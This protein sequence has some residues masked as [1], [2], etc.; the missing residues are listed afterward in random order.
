M[1]DVLAYDSEEL[2]VGGYAQSPESDYN[3]DSIEDEEEDS[4]SDASDLESSPEVVRHRFQVNRAN[5]HEVGSRQRQALEDEQRN[6]RT[7]RAARRN[8]V[9]EPQANENRSGRHR[10]GSQPVSYTHLTLPTI[11][12]V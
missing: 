1:P 8:E 10:R 3:E 7:A 5:V 12:R 11:L 6:R 9:R 2:V 4:A